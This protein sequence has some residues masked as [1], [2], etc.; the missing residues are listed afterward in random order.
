MNNNIIVEFDYKNDSKIINEIYREIKTECRYKY[1]LF[2][3]MFIK[4]CFS[5]IKNKN[6]KFILNFYN[7]DIEV[8]YIGKKTIILQSEIYSIK[9]DMSNVTLFYKRYMKKIIYVY[10]YKILLNK[11]V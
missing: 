11:Y 7:T 10:L 9:I 6:D 1:I 2:M 8:E 3:D 5:N 4:E